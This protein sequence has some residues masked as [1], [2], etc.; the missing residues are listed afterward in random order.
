ME[1]A[2]QWLES[3]REVMYDESYSGFFLHE[4]GD[5]S[6]PIYN[7]PI[8]FG[9]QYFCSLLEGGV[10]C[11]PRSLLSHFQ[12]ALSAFRSLP[13]SLPLSLSFS[14]SLSLSCTRA[15]DFRNQS[16]REY[17]V[18]A[19]LASISDPAV[20][21]T[22]SDDVDGVPAEHPNA[23]ANTGLSPQDLADLRY[24]T[25]EASMELIQATTL[26]TKYNWQAFGAGDG[27]PSGVSKGNCATWMRAR[28]TAAYQGSSLI[29]GMDNSPA[30][31]N[32][33]VAGFLVVRPAYAYLGWGWESDDR[34]WNDLFYLE[35]GEPMAGPGGLCTETSTGV[36]SRQW[37]QGTVTLDCNSWAA[38]LPFSMLAH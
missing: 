18:S 36:F 3:Q 34:M 13:P 14:L 11:A 7:E 35:A 20:D 27:I 2:L 6:S 30:N 22:F 1:L 10:L 12:C 23:P 37:T 33:S 28:C 17:F 4:K 32:Q 19:T 8:S 15:G 24:A 5:P 38:S 21:G 26:A 25:Q 31:A 16:V 29:M 9:D